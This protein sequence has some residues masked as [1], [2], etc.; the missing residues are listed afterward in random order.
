LLLA[1]PSLANVLMPIALLVL[2]FANDI[3]LAM[4]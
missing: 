3:G 2:S 1:G 4:R